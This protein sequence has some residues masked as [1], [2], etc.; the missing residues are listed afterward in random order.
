MNFIKN[1]RTSKK[2]KKETLM[3]VS[4]WRNTLLK[5]NKNDLQVLGMVLNRE[6]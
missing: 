5:K 1:E 4:M 6:R 2:K 3:R